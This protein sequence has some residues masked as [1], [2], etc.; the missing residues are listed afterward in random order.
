[1]NNLKDI[2]GA[3]LILTSI[4]DAL[5]YT[6]QANKIRQ[7]CTAKSMSRKFINLALLNDFVKL[8]YGFIIK[9]L[10]II[11]SSAL[12]LVCMLDLFWQIYWWYP[13]RKRGLINFHRPDIFTYFINSLL[14]NRIRKRL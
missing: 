4:G 5:K 7:T 10:F 1:M 14:P 9:D 12:A 8:G 13:Y 2:F 6:I 3:L 11:T